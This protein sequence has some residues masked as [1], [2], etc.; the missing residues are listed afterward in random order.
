MN[1]LLFQD[2][3]NTLEQRHLP[4]V[5]NDMTIISCPDFDS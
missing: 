3:E 5:K 1:E 2:W 4:Q